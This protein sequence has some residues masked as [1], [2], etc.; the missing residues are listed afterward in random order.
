MQ[1]VVN[2][3]VQSL[4]LG[5]RLWLVPGNGLTSFQAKTENMQLI[6]LLSF[7]IV[8]FELDGKNSGSWFHCL[9]IR[10]YH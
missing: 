4:G 6:E 5:F 1:F 9:P 8:E 10:I 3:V 7:A 2:N